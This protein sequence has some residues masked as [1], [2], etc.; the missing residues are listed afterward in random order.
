MPKILNPGVPLVGLNFKAEA[1]FEKCY[2]LPVAS[3]Q[4]NDDIRTIEDAWLHRCEDNDD[5]SVVV[6]R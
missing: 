5:L 6:N 4:A 3:I 2:F 1:H